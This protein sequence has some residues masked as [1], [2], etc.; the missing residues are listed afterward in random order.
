LLIEKCFKSVFEL[1]FRSIME[2]LI[3]DIRST[4]DNYIELS[5]HSDLGR[6]PCGSEEG[7]YSARTRGPVD[8]K[9]EGG[10]ASRQAS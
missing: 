2:F 3:P 8:Q 6:G 10:K 7:S 4:S 5:P 1:R 9:G